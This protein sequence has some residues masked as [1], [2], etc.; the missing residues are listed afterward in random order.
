MNNLRREFTQGFIH[1]ELIQATIRRKKM[2][3]VWMHS[4]VAFA[5]IVALGAQEEGIE[6]VAR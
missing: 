3:S 5:G 6:H 4:M 1:H 2:A